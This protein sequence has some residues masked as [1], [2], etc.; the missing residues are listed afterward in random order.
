[1]TDGERLK[2]VLQ[3]FFDGNLKMLAERDRHIDPELRDAAVSR[4]E[5]VLAIADAMGVEIAGRDELDN[6][7]N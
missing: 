4:A 2:A 3:E 7:R 6:Y 5:E 1:M